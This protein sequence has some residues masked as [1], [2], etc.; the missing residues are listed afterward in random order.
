ML[1]NSTVHLL[2]IFSGTYC[3]VSERLCISKDAPIVVYLRVSVVVYLKGRVHIVV[4]C[5]VSESCSL[6]CILE[7]QYLLLCI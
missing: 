5:R 1:C 2:R 7:I 4:F 6:L 3:F